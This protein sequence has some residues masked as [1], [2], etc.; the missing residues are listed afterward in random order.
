MADAA[1]AL[2]KDSP[3]PTGWE[4]EDDQGTVSAKLTGLVDPA[5]GRSHFTV[6]VTDDLEDLHVARLFVDGVL[7]SEATRTNGGIVVRSS[8]AAASLSGILPAQYGYKVRVEW[9]SEDGLKVVS[10]SVS[11][12]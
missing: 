4:L 8:S 9:V 12:H 2:A 3:L 7:Q 5:T 1:V 11:P 6:S 10:R